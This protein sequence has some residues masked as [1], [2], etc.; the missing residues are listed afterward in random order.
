MPSAVSLITWSLH[1]DGHFFNLK[2]EDR[3][4][5]DKPEDLPSEINLIALG[6]WGNE[7]VLFKYG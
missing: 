3:K 7:S 4:L 5:R 2:R 1:S 6:I